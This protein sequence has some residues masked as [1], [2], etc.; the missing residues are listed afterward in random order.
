MNVTVVCDNCGSCAFRDFITRE[1]AF[2]KHEAKEVTK[3]K[4]ECRNCHIPYTVM[5]KKDHDQ[6]AAKRADIE[7]ED[8]LSPS[9]PRMDN[10]FVTRYTD[11]SPQ[12]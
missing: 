6:P 7:A 5:I 3:L 12:R 1:I 11:R 10:N 9:N 4:M 8:M 2:I